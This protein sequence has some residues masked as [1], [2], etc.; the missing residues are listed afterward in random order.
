MMTAVMTAE[1]TMIPILLLN[2]NPNPMRLTQYL[3]PT[4][5][6][7]QMARHRLVGCSRHL[8]GS[9]KMLVG[10]GPQHRRLSFG[11]PDPFDGKDLK[12]L[13]G[14]LLQCK[15][16][17]QAK[18]EYIR[19]DTAKVTYV[20]SFLKELAVDYFKRFLVND[21]ADEPAWLTKFKLFTEELYIY[22]GPYDQQAEA[23]IELEQLVMKDNH[24]V[25]KFFV[26]FYQI[27]AMLD[28]NKSSLY[29][30]AYTAMPKRI[31]VEMVHFDKP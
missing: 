13:R 5:M 11:T 4:R 16:N 2:P 3:I 27:S 22:F 21:P 30:K 31:K 19:D 29:R 7:R 10:I 26:E 9:R 24:K 14:F 12:K 6:Q 28:H 18:L 20:L 8:K 1:A 23:K 15:L 17:F 25:T